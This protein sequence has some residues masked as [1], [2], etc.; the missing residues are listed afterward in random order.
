MPKDPTPRLN[1]KNPAT[2]E[3][4]WDKPWWENTK[5]LDEHPG[6][7][8]VTSE[9]LPKEPW[10]GQVVFNTDNL[11]LLI[12]EGNNWLKFSSNFLYLQANSEINKGELVI[13]NNSG[14]IDSLINYPSSIEEFS[15]IIGI[16]VQNITVNNYGIVKNNGKIRFS[17]WNLTPGKIY[18]L[19]E[20]ITLT[21][22]VPNTTNKII[23]G[24]AINSDTLMFN[25]SYVVS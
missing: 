24:V 14:L 6:I 8:V 10:S 3:F 13:L 17:G 16:A 9:T 20:N 25:K 22:S 12:W 21:N 7:K 11:S 19:N 23:L 15:R 4:D 1:L 18:Y 5:I 2:G